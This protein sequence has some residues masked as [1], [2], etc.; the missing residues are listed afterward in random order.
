MSLMQSGRGA[1]HLIESHIQT[2]WAVGSTVCIA[3]PLV[4]FV[5]MLGC[6]LL[7]RVQPKIQLGAP[8]WRRAEQLEIQGGL[9]EHMKPVTKQ[10]AQKDLELSGD[11]DDEGFGEDQGQEYGV[12]DA[13]AY[14]TTNW[15]SDPSRRL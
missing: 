14:S 9:G 1:Q 2:L 5:V 10:P 15:M 4:A 7:L 12:D 13:A 3:S 11:Q 6:V 8:K